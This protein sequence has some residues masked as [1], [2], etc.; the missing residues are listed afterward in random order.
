MNLVLTNIKNMLLIV[1]V[2]N[3]CVDDKFSKLFKSY[4]RKDAICNFIN[5]MIEKS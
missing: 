5:S 2:I 4:L 3:Y 1:M